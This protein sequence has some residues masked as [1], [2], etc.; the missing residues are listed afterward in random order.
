M[1][2]SHCIKELAGTKIKQLQMGDET[3]R[4]CLLAEQGQDQQLERMQ[5]HMVR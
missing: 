4:V 5:Q 2:F 1:K 3:S